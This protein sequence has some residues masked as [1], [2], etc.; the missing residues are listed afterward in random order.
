MG[1]QICHMLLE[2]FTTYKYGEAMYILP[3]MIIPCSFGLT[4][5]SSAHLTRQSLAQSQ[6]S[7]QRGQNSGIKKPSPKISLGMTDVCIYQWMN[8]WLGHT[9]SRSKNFST[10]LSFSD[11][12]KD[13]VKIHVYWTGGK[14]KCKKDDNVAQ[15]GDKQDNNMSA[16]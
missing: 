11:F 2:T 4:W 7:L 8:L 16:V 3:W 9:H 6:T 1:L 14:E 15:W 12:R 13:S 5:Q 10:V